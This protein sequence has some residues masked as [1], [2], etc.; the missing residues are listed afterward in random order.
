MS[1]N[2]LFCS[3]LALLAVPLLAS[4]QGNRQASSTV[5]S[6]TTTTTTTTTTV[7]VPTSTICAS[8]IN[9]STA[10]RRRRS[11]EWLDTPIL[12]SLD[13]DDFYDPYNP[14]LVFKYTLFYIKSSSIR[15]INFVRQVL[16]RPPWWV[17][18]PNRP[19]SSRLRATRSRQRKRMTRSVLRNRFT[20]RNWPP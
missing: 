2:V 14:T 17:S 12:L 9:A 20:S 19:S 5:T 4:P 13:D 3:L 6:T 1:H 7:T 8:Y 15:V 16:N 18:C 10:C 11:G